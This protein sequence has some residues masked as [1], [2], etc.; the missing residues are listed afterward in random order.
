MKR[1]EKFLY[2]KRLVASVVDTLDS[3][4]VLHSFKGAAGR[5]GEMLPDAFSVIALQMAL[6][7]KVK[8]MNFERSSASCIG[9]N[10]CFDLEL[11]FTKS[12]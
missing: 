5:A 2:D 12:P 3:M 1:L 10:A 8:Q 4:F 6:T 7:A 9:G 11:S